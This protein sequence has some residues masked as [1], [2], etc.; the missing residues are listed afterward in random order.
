MSEYLVWSISL[1]ST[2]EEKQ[3]EERA[4]RKTNRKEKK[5]NDKCIFCE[6]QYDVRFLYKNMC[7][8]ILSS[9]ETVQHEECFLLFWR[10][11]RARNS[12]LMQKNESKKKIYE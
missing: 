12:L 3:N 10:F 5:E 8:C 11:I 1:A 4:A 7:K 6:N 2:R 9:S